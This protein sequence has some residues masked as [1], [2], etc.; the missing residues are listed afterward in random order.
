VKITMTRHGLLLCLGLLPVL[1]AAGTMTWGQEASAMPT[2]YSAMMRALQPTMTFEV[3]EENMNAYLKTRP[4]ELNMPEGFEEPRVALAAG[5]FEVSARKD[6]VLL[7]TRVRVGLVPQVVR[8]RL[9]L[10]V[11]RIH[12]GP[13]PLPTSFHM[14]VADTI[15]GFINAILDRNEMQLVSVVVEKRIVRVTAKMTPPCPPAGL[16][17]AP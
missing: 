13:I 1:L 15:E 7:H 2:D 4:A 3:T 6:L 14:G 17:T 9:R 12:A 10:K 11:G 8:G 16:E 5:V